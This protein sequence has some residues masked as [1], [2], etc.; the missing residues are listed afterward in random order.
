MMGVMIS[1]KFVEKFC[2]LEIQETVDVIVPIPQGSRM[3]TQAEFLCCSLEENSFFG[4][5]QSLLLK[6]FTDSTIP[7]YFMEDSL[8]YSKST[9]INI[10][11]MPQILSQQHPGLRLTKEIPNLAP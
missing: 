3:K 10:N 4:I 6:P 1:P 8:L 2:R 11:Y 9:D 7:T 5:P